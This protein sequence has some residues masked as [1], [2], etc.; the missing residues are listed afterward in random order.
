M[1]NSTPTAAKL[2][3]AKD[4]SIG[5]VVKP[6]VSTDYR[7]VLSPKLA[8]PPVRV[9]VSPRVRF[10]Q[11][12]ERT[13]LRGL[14]RPLLPGATVAVQRL[15]GSAWRSV[16]TATLAPDGNFEAQLELVP[17]SYRA[18]VAPGRGFVPG[19]SP[20]LKVLSQ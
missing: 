2:K 4:R 18:R 5:A 3:P 6:V 19:V 17:G 7:L 15:E 12:T 1:T 13:A 10:R 20:V 9:R 16:A 11:V 8:A 14:V